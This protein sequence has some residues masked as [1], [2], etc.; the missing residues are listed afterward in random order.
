MIKLISAIMSAVAAAVPAEAPKHI[1]K[2]PLA[3]IGSLIIMQEEPRAADGNYIIEG[4][5]QDR[6]NELKAK[7]DERFEHMFRLKAELEK[8]QSKLS[9]KWEEYHMLNERYNRELK[10]IIAAWV[11]ESN[12]GDK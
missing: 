8:A 12:Y 5:A 9:A 11:T 3:G 7:L 4:S 1:E 2:P 6:Y 10:K